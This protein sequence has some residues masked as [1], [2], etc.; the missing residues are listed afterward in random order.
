MPSDNK[1]IVLVSAEE[2]AAVARAVCDWLYKC[3]ERPLSLRIDFEWLDEEK[4]LCVS[5]MQSAYKTRQYIDGTYEAQYQ[6]HI[7]Y[8]TV[9]MDGDE[10]LAADE[11]LNRFAAWAEA[12]TGALALADGL[13]VRKVKRDTNAAIIGR[14][15][16][17]SE[18][19]QI[20]MTLIYEVI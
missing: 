8:R 2:S 14:Y 13:R 10:R 17:G 7:L 11:L 5:T 9:P 12:N 20:N 15:E 16:D 18:D 4:G 3:P 1:P 19:H 6:Y